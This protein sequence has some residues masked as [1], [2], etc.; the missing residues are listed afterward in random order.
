[1][2]D[3]NKQQEFITRYMNLY[4]EKDGSE[5]TPEPEE[6]EKYRELEAE[7]MKGDN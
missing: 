1:M 2:L 4:H 6:L 5:R 3:K 7:L